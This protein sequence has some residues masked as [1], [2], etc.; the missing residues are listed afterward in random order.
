VTA[1]RLT[2][3][4]ATKD[5]PDYLRGA[6][7][8]LQASARAA[9]GE[10][11]AR[12]LVVDDAD[13][14]SAQPIAEATGADYAFN[15][16]RDPRRNPSAARIHGLSLVDTELVALFDDD[17]IALPGHLG[18]QLRE[19]DRGADVCATG[20]WVADPD[21]ADATRLVPVR[22]VIPRQA[23]LGDLLLG[24]QPITDQSMFRTEAARSVTWDVERQNTMLYDVF[25]QLLLAG[26]RIARTRQ[27][28]FLYRQH[29]TSLSKTLDAADAALR[30]QLF[31]ERRADAAARFGR[32]PGPSPEIRLRLLAQRLRG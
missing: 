21:P 20:Y 27:A 3:L 32:V 31:A 8:S 11:G 16:V 19:I 6:V 7:E 15:P 14:R 23:R 2:V 30:Q 12:V 24:F 29:P 1:P 22:K 17:D 26:R 4:I 18:A 25:L 28:T 10:G 9:L 5:R 13:S